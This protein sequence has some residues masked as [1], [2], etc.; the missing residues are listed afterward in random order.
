MLMAPVERCPRGGCPDGRF[1]VEQDCEAADRTL[2]RLCTWTPKGT[3][4]AAH[5][6]LRE[7]RYLDSQEAPG[8]PEGI[9]TPRRHLD[10]QEASA[11]FASLSP[12]DL[13][14]CYHCDLE[15]V[16]QGRPVLGAGHLGRSPHIS[17]SCQAPQ[18]RPSSVSPSC[19]LTCYFPPFFCPSS[20]FLSCVSPPLFL[21]SCIPSS[22]SG[23]HHQPLPI[24]PASGTIHMFQCGFLSPHP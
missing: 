23:F 15:A 14:S 18:T 24:A 22:L 21:Y 2:D 4:G 8:L 5:C 19:L 1:Y 20:F 9:W 13:P 11:W 17:C 3:A 16:L 6:V 10:S 7:P 12:K